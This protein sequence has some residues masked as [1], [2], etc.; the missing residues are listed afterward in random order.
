ML[1]KNCRTISTV[2]SVKFQLGAIFKPEYSP[3]TLQIL[4]DPRRWKLLPLNSSSWLPFATIDSVIVDLS[5][6]D[7]SAVGSSYTYDMQ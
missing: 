1:P 5:F 4:H 3:C 2:W 6:S 7:S